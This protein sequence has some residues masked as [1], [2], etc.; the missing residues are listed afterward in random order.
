LNQRKRYA[1]IQLGAGNNYSNFDLID[2]TIATLAEIGK[3]HPV[4]AE[5]LTAETSLDL[6]PKVPRLR[7]FPISRYYR[8]FDF[9]VSAVGY[10]SFNEIISFGLP[11]V[12]VPNLNQT[13]DDQTAR[14]VY[15]DKH[16]AAVHL[17]ADLRPMLREVIAAMHDNGIRRNMVQN[18]RNLA[19]P[20]GAD[21]AANLVARVAAHTGG[22]R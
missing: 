15:A 9:T 10:N 13:M 2:R 20:N 18:C 6:W 11:S 14:A 21:E 22:V 7:C 12:L 3:V 1:L 4:I 19:R 5:W 8:A 17:D 16:E